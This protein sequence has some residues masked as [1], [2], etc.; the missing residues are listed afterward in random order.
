M[1][2]ARRNDWHALS[3]S[4]VA[5]LLDTESEQ[6]LSADEAKQRLDQVGP[7]ALTQK[8]DQNP[9]LLFLQQFNQPLVYILLGASL[10]TALL[11]EWVDSGV[12]F[13]VVLVNAVIGFLQE[14]KA[15]KAIR[16]LSQAMVSEATV[17]RD[18]LKRR[19][20]SAELVPGDIVVLQSGD[21]VPADIRLVRS[22]ELQIDESALTGESVPVEKQVDAVAKDC[23][24]ADRSNMAYGSTLV[25]YGTATGVV[26]ATGDRSEIGRINELIATAEVLATPLT[27]RIGQFSHM[28]L[29]VILALAAFTFLIGILRGESWIEMFMAAVA[30]AVGAIP[31][32]LP[33]ALTITLAIGVG[34]MAKRH[35]IIRKLPAVE[36]LG[37]TTIICSDKTG[38]LTQ[39]QMTVQEIHAAGLK[40]SVSGVGYAPEGSFSL[41]GNDYP[42]QNHPA[43]LECLKAG[44]LCNDSQLVKT[45]EG[46]RI[47]GDPTEG[48]LITSAHKAGLTLDSLLQSLPRIDAIPFESQH[49]YMA[50]LHQRADG[51]RLVYLKGS[52]ESLIKRCANVLDETGAI[53][54][55]DQARCHR[56]V[57]SMA[58][59]GMRVLAFA[60]AELADDQAQISHADLVEGL[61]FIGLQGMID[62]P[63][64]EAV[65]A[66]SACQ[67]AGISVKMITGD[68]AVTAAAIAQ[69]IGL[70]G[71]RLE[72]GRLAAVT[73]HELAEMSDEQVEHLVGH[74]A[75]FAR[76]APEQK[77]R[78]VEA[79][80]RRGDVVAMTG[81]GVNDA[82]ALRRADIGV[83]MGIT[84]T[85]VSKEAADMVLT[86]D[87]FA[88]IRAAVEEGRGVY[89]NLIKFITWTLPTNLGE[90]LVILTAIF[91]G[92]S[93]PILPVQILWINMST[94]VFLGLM[95]AFEPK[96]P[97][98]MERPPR[99]PQSNILSGGLIMR[100]LLVGFLLLVGAYGLFEWELAQGESELVARTVTV[101]VFVFGELFYLFNCRSLR[102]S[103][104]KL[105]FF[106]NP[107][108]LV[109]VAGMILLQL[110]YTYSPMMN[111]A[112]GSAPIGAAE[113]LN[114]L[115]VSF[116]IYAVIGIEKWWLRHKLATSSIKPEAKPESK[117][118]KQSC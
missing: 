25:T 11:Q 54:E 59:N 22:R 18:G 115:S 28:L 66:V 80:Q 81:D 85:E 4:E 40:L 55:L 12:I 1:S 71:K 86:N 107:L 35:A 7:N 77:L 8:Q 30:L 20:S 117:P 84:G 116:G 65:E 2:P 102:Y 89:D 62:P 76:V 68:H 78:L 103:V 110:F 113:W 10:I 108:L 39:N 45:D 63:R 99:D 17:I 57:E 3:E 31:E 87:N 32:G 93:L 90:G 44:L 37:S 79:M 42:P 64:P 94:A 38:T 70:E 61:T 53:A 118:Q 26:V 24:L 27:R 43:L 36:T 47:E 92:L 105:G 100:I 88:S 111:A 112:F 114:I 21:K 60:V 33:A 82:P 15:M 74:I 14:S 96:E 50:T 98:I 16:A 73:G 83:A 52:V 109:G 29:R 75:V 19:L 46:W 67:S 69:E 41:D 51:K 9:F 101:N 97:G 13:G 72:N 6:G 48:A 95:L 58:A 49:Q 56:E 104:F 91:A 23:V 5:D 34:K 106:S